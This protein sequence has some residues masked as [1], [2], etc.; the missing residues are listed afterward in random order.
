MPLDRLLSIINAEEFRNR[1]IS[2]KLIKRAFKEGNSET[3]KILFEKLNSIFIFGDE[4][5]RREIIECVYEG[6]RFL[7]LDNIIDIG[8]NSVLGNL[9]VLYFIIKKHGIITSEKSEVLKILSKLK[10]IYDPLT[11]ELLPLTDKIIIELDERIVAQNKPQEIA[12]IAAI[13]EWLFA[14]GAIVESKDT[15]TGMVLLYEHSP[16]PEQKFKG[17]IISSL[18]Y[19]KADLFLYSIRKLV[20]EIEEENDLLAHYTKIFDALSRACVPVY[21]NV[22]NLKINAMLFNDNF[23]FAKILNKSGVERL[24][25]PYQN[26]ETG[27]IQKVYDLKTET[28]I[29]PKER[30]GKLPFH[31]IFSFREVREV[32]DVSDEQIAIVKGLKETE[33]E[34]R[35]RWILSDL[36]PTPHSPGEKTDIFELK[37][38]VNNDN[39]LRNTAF[40]LKG[41]GYPKIYLDSIASNL[42]KAIDLPVEIIVLIHTGIILDEALEKFIKQCDSAKKM[43]CRIDS[44]D[45]ARLLKAYDRLTE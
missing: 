40:I 33:I 22:D 9:V 20:K 4:V 45:L 14:N 42:L 17:Q 25:W 38:L 39:D 16:L 30:I 29:T 7:A 37:L 11:L 6:A 3:L 31:D 43:Y 35:I 19:G 10:F 21:F 2:E 26:I 12:E 24:L 44:R 18:F 27:Q 1:E 41:R 8:S 13:C 32:A 36:N 5:F 23:F 15:I 28:Y 34:E